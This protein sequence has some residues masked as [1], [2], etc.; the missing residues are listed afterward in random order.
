MSDARSN[1]G[2]R[3]KVGSPYT[4]DVGEVVSLDIPEI[5]A[6]ALEAT[7]HSSG[8]WKESVS[9]NL[10]ELVE[11]TATINFTSAY[12]ATIYADLAAGTVKSYQVQFPDDGLTKWTFDAIVTGLKPLSADA[13]SPEVLQAEVKF[14]PTGANVVS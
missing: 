5:V 10:K 8:G 12:I 14:Q 4:T 1:Y 7:S 13:G 3:L 9:G 2:V 6:E 11:F